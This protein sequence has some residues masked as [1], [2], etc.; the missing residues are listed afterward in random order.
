MAEPN[1][2]GLC[3]IVAAAA[4]RVA[5][6]ANADGVA[7]AAIGIGHDVGGHWAVTAQ[8]AD[9]LSGLRFLVGGDEGVLAGLRGRELE[10]LVLR[11]QGADLVVGQEVQDRAGVGVLVRNFF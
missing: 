3:E 8:T 1:D 9:Q 5:V 7:V 2:P 6:V 11:S 10:R 4:A